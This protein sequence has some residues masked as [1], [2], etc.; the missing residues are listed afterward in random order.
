MQFVIAH[1]NI[2]WF[3][4]KVGHISICHG[5]FKDI[6]DYFVWHNFSYIILVVSLANGPLMANLCLCQMY[7]VN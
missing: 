6:F 1:Y 3:L 4:D 5:T 2:V 7:I